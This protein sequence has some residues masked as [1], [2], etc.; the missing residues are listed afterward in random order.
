[1]TKVLHTSKQL[2]HFKSNFEFVTLEWWFITWNGKLNF[3]KYDCV[4]LIW[5]LLIVWLS[6]HFPEIHTE[7]LTLSIDS[8]V[9]ILLTH[10]LVCLYYF[11]L[12]PFFL[13]TG[14]FFLFFLSGGS[15]SLFGNFSSLK[16]ILHVWCIVITWII[17]KA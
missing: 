15:F 10:L 1:M 4:P 8:A 16:G 12:C 11:I 3:E 13:T 2:D 9:S 6:D 7:V 14:P 5:I 17:R